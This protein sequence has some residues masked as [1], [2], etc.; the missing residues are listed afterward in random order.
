MI[1]RPPRSTLF[2]YTTLFRSP[3]GQAIPTMSTG[4]VSL[5]HYE[6]AAREAFHVIADSINDADKLVADRHRHR[7]R[8]LRPSVPVID[9]HVSATDRCFQ[10][11]DEHVVAADFWNWNFLEPETGLGFGFHNGLHCLQHEWKL[12]KVFTDSHRFLG[13][14]S[15]LISRES[16]SQVQ[17]FNWD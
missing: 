17:C 15:K 14:I 4:D 6:I 7:D 13:T 11:A 5:A 9:V 2:P 16:A 8:L 1:R 12:S 3:P 10:H